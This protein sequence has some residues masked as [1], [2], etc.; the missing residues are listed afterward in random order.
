MVL[1]ITALGELDA[2][3]IRRSGAKVGDLVYLSSLP[4]L[5]AA[6]MAILKRDLDRPRY[7]VE[8]H[9]NPKLVKPDNLMKVASAMCDVSDGLT[10]DAGHIAK[11]S[12][13][14]INFVSEQLI[15]ATD[16]KD[17]QELATELNEDV[18]DWILNGGEDHFFIATVDPTKASDELGI[19]AGVVVSGNGQI[20][21]DNKEIKKSGYQH[22]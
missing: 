14:S 20:M 8:A 12:K 19:Q 6:G 10:I 21:L 4:G 13:V 3:P 17:L 15:S 2:D 18:F 22:F 1:S 7:V 5:S 11:D 16:F 9:L